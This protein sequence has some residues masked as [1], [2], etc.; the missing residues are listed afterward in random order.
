M[1]PLQTGTIFFSF[2]LSKIDPFRHPYSLIPE[3]GPETPQK[4][5]GTA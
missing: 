2:S 4:R 3:N 1:E 5:E